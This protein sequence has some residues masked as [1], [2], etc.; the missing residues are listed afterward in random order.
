MNCENQFSKEFD[1]RLGRVATRVFWW[2]KPPEA[3]SD[4]NRFVAQ[5]MTFGAWS[6]IQTTLEVFGEHTFR[7]V[8]LKPPPGVFD[9]KS[10]NYWHIRFGMPVPLLPKRR[11]E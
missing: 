7:G 5:A 6:D 11:F 9:L 8:L 3:L 4:I 10:W 2:K 1:E